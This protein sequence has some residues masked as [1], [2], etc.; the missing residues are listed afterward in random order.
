MTSLTPDNYIFK[1]GKFINKRA[2]DVLKIKKVNPKTGKMENEGYLYMKWLVDKT[3]WFK[4][5]QIIEEI[6]DKYENEMTD[7]DTET[8][9]E[10]EEIKKPKITKEAKTSE[11]KPKKM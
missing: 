1:F 10:V 8:E 3:D 6:L 7:D 4:H 2:V 5:K 9:E 11:K